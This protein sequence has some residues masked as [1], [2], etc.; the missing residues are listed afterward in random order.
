M[1][2]HLCC[3]GHAEF[4]LLGVTGVGGNPY[5]LL[6]GRPVIVLEQ[7]PALGAVGDIA[8]IDP[9]Q[10][11]L[12]DGGEKTAMSVHAH[13]DSDEIVFRF[14]WRVDGKG[15]YSSPITPFNGSQTRS[16]FVTLAAR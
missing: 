11:I 15:A 10:Y 3:C 14:T 5:P 1:K 12:I 16:P 2:P 6:K 8:L 13:F 7:C 4:Q 9:S